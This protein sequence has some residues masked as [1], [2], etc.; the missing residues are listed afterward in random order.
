MCFRTCHVICE[1]IVPR[2]AMFFIFAARGVLH[3]LTPEALRRNTTLALR[4]SIFCFKC[5]PRFG[6]FFLSRLMQHTHPI[7]PSICLDHK[8]SRHPSAYVS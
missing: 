3:T 7:W 8:I 2:S 5:S 6:R 1:S 4:S